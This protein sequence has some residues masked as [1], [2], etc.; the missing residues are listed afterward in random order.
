[1]AQLDLKL[2]IAVAKE[3]GGIEMGVLEDGTPFLNSAGL[4]QLWGMA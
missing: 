4:A 1:M 2:G 3:I